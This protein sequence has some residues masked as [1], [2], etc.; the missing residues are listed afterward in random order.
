[1]KIKDIFKRLNGDIILNFSPLDN[2]LEDNIVFKTK[3]KKEMEDVLDSLFNVSFERK[4]T[5]YLFSYDTYGDDSGEEILVTENPLHIIDLL[6]EVQWVD[7]YLFEYNSYEDA[8]KDALTMREPRK[9]CY[10]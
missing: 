1:M 5:V 9:L 2:V 8:Y 10:N 3:T 7:F 4:D 6:H